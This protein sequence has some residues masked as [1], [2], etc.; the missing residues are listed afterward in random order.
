VATGFAVVA[1]EVKTLARQPSSA[2]ADIALVTRAAEET[3]QAAGAL[4]AVAT[5]LSRHAETLLSATR[6]F[7]EAVRA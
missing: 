7:V 4:L 6:Q 5:D 2:T 3:N 1:T